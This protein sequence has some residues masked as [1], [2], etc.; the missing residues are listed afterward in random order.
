MTLE[1]LGVNGSRPLMLLGDSVATKAR[2]LEATKIQERSSESVRNDL[3]QQS[4]LVAAACNP[5][6][7]DK[8]EM[9][10]REVRSATEQSKRTIASIC[11][12]DSVLAVRARCAFRSAS[13]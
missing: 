6:Y 3:E 10:I 4:R 8:V 13:R 5:V 2:F 11:A 7:L 1:E 12:T 9:R